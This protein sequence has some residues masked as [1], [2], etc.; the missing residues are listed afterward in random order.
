MKHSG[1]SVFLI[2]RFFL[3]LVSCLFV[4]PE[5]SCSAGCMPGKRPLYFTADTTL[6]S[7]TPPG[8][9]EKLLTFLQDPLLEIGYCITDLDSSVFSDTAAQEEMIMFVAMEVSLTEKRSAV[10]PDNDTAGNLPADTVMILD[11]SASLSVALIQVDGWSAAARRRAR[12]SPLL[13]LPYRPGD[14]STLTSVLV[15]KIIENLRMQYICHLR[16][17]SVPDGVTIRSRTGL[18]GVT[19]LEWITPVGR[20]QITGELEGYEPIRRKIDL[21]APGMHT[22]VLQMRRRQFYHSRFFIPTIIL[23]VSSVGCFVAERYFYNRYRQLGKEERDRKPDLF[24]QK[25]TIAQNFERAA[26]GGLFLTGVS[27]VLCFVY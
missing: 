5:D 17:Q 10:Q 20:V 14:L 12:E 2:Y 8:F 19:P 24:R 18:E 9:S 25:F 27:A 22:Y 26:A 15:R 7:I 16:V 6:R 11:T 13:T 4:F 23:G 3:L 1:I 21:N